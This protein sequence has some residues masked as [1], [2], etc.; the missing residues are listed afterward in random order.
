MGYSAYRAWTSGMSSFNPATRELTKVGTKDETGAQHT[1]NTS[2]HQQGATLYTI[3]LVLNLI[4]MPLFFHFKRPVEATVD[5][6][7]LTGVTGYLTYIWG[8][9]DVVAG[10]TL[11]PYLAW[12][13]F[14][15][16]LTVWTELLLAILC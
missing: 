10:W 8:Q 16:Y 3:Q 13:G 4:W 14:A 9:V 5:I 12:L 6:A 11:V 15:S 7:L 1:N 2:F